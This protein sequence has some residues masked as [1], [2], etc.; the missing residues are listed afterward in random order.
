MA[1]NYKTGGKEFKIPEQK[2]IVD[3]RSK[4]SIRGKSYVAKGDENSAK[5]AK[6]RPA[7]VTWF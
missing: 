5:V 6:A 3:P 1:W 4:T 2:K 7:K